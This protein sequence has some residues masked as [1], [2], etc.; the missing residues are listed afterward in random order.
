MGSG[1]IHS[2]PSELAT[3]SKESDLCAVIASYNV[4]ADCYAQKCIR[5]PHIA[6]WSLRKGAIL[7]E[8]EK[9]DADIICLQEVLIV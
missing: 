3:R 9:L 2:A 6:L 4:L 7:A 8:I 1:W 5:D